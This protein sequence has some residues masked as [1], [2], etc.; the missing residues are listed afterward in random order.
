MALSFFK[1][2]LVQLFSMHYFFIEIILLLNS[3]SIKRVFYHLS[4]INR[5]E[6]GGDL[7][8]EIQP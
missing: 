1:V 6:N 7:G 4:F 8:V 5:G 3:T 2:A